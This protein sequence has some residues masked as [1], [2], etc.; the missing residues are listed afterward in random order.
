MSSDLM[1]DKIKKLKKELRKKD[2][3]ASNLHLL[4]GMFDSLYY[5]NEKECDSCEWL[6]EKYARLQ[7]K[8]ANEDI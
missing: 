6:I 1:E 4:L 7:I 3:E 5:D 8:I 2:N